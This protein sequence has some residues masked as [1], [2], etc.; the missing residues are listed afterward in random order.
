MTTDEFTSNRKSPI[1]VFG[2]VQCLTLVLGSCLQANDWVPEDKA[3]FLNALR[4]KDSQFDN[5]SVEYEKRTET[6]VDPLM[7]LIDR[8]QGAS[9]AS[10]EPPSGSDDLDVYTKLV[11][12]EKILVVRGEQTTLTVKGNASQVSG[13]EAKQV[14]FVSKS[15]N[16]SGVLKNTVEDPTEFV[17]HD[18]TRPFDETNLLAED[19]MLDEFCFGVGFGKRI[20]E[21]ESI[22]VRD[23]MAVVEAKMLLWR[24][25]PTK[26]R[27]TI[28]RNFLVRNADLHYNNSGHEARFV[29]VTK[30]LTQSPSGAELATSGSLVKK[31]L[32][33]VVRGKRVDLGGAVRDDY[34]VVVTKVTHDLSD[35]AYATLVD[36]NEDEATR[37]IDMTPA[38]REK[39]KDRSGRVP[40]GSS[41]F[42]IIIA[43]NAAF[44]VA[45][46]LFHMWK[47]IK[48]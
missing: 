38:S 41:W 22:E 15:S 4:T 44:V 20:T 16:V 13:S 36:L 8:P 7:E 34:E 3:V 9:K 24:D 40:S 11:V 19:R 35:T 31:G 46:G 29:V 14:P 43:I 37:H 17:F 27:L 42:P 23:E 33:T 32:A 25:I 39:Y 26:A 18:D 1:S 2:F 48:Q 21:I 6:T 5:L 47:R 28:D 12:V 10:V 45:F 30:G